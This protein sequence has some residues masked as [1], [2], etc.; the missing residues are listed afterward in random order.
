MSEEFAYTAAVFTSLAAAVCWVR[1][2]L[3][4]L[5]SAGEYV[6]FADF[7]FCAQL[8]PVSATALS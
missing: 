6:S 1:L 4:F 5:S 7:L 8:L 3:S 2:A